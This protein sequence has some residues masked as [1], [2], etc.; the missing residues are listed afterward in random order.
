MNEKS[1][2]IFLKGSSTLEFF[3]GSTVK[4]NERKESKTL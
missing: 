4:R 3:E 1:R 2:E